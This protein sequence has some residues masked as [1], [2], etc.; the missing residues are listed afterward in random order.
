M[1][2]KARS[3]RFSREALRENMRRNATASRATADEMA[4]MY[5][6]CDDELWPHMLAGP[7]QLFRDWIDFTDRVCRPIVEAE[8]DPAAVQAALA[9]YRKANPHFIALCMVMA[10]NHATSPP[11][12]AVPHTPTEEMTDV[13]DR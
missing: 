3:V 1:S 12:A 5:D 4:A 9:L 8:D 13:H 11:A 10:A 6:G 7:D 2:G